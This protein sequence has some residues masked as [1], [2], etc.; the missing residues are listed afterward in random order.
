MHT[1]PPSADQQG[2]ADRD[3][4]YSVRSVPVRIYLPDGPVIQDLVPPLLDD[5]I[6]FICQAIVFIQFPDAPHT[7][8]RFLESHIPLLFP[9]RPPPPP[10]SRTNPNPQPGPVQ[11]LAYALIQGV[12]TPLDSEMAWLGACLAGADGWV[13]VCIGILQS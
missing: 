9:A 4:A 11:E 13:N 2:P 1:R 12:I 3:G 8:G 5:G 6:K 10:P 7:L